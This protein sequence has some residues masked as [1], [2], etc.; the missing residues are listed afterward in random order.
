MALA[1]VVTVAMVASFVTVE[2]KGC[3]V[4]VSFLV[5]EV[6]LV[7]CFLSDSLQVSD[8]GETRLN[9]DDNESFRDHKLLCRIDD[10]DFDFLN[11]DS[12]RWRPLEFSSVANFQ[13]NVNDH[14]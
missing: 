10:D 3:V 12:R 2:V 14:D 4:V 13:R 5:V 8:L 9:D 11:V 6:V 1:V 7:T